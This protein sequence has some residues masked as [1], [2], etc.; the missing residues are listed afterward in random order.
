MWSWDFAFSILPQ[1]LE[2]MVV[3]IEAT[4]VG[5]LVAAVLGLFWTICRRS[6]IKP[7]KFVVVAIVEFIRST[8]L[9][10]QL[11][12]I[13]FVFPTF[14]ITLSP[15]LA[16]VLGLG[17][18]Y[19]TYLTEVFRTGIDSI[20]KG[21][22][23]ASTALNLSKVKVWTHVIMPQAI[24]PVIPMLGNYFIVMFKETP[25]LSAISIVE[26]VQAAQIIGSNSFRYVEAFTDVG[27]I[28]LLLSYPA[29]LLFQYMEKR[30]QHR[31]DLPVKS[32]KLEEDNYAA[33]K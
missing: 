20:P 19:S 4:I 16:G 23:E 10:V 6:S 14:G 33:S 31:F 24:P 27:V 11:Y 12:F 17:L 3:T 8:P 29:S 25:L 5:F 28:F 7:L 26:M 22:W 15:F 2:A 21:Q 32:S 30:I 13:F 9:L 18:H 1:L